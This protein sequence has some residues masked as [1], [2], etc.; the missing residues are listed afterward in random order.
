M[1]II[2]DALVWCPEIGYYLN[3]IETF[4]VATAANLLKLSRAVYDPFNYLYTDFIPGIRKLRPWTESRNRRCKSGARG[5]S[6][7]G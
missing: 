2:Y 7:S 1:I 3:G 5:Q 4:S 6:G